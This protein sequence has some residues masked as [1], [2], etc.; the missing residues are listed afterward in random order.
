MAE[1]GDQRLEVSFGYRTLWAQLLPAKVRRR[2]AQA[3][4]EWSHQ[5]VSAWLAG[6]ETKHAELVA[7]VE[8]ARSQAAQSRA[9]A[10]GTD[11]SAPADL[12]AA[13]AELAEVS[14]TIQ[15]EILDAD[16][17]EEAA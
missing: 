13:E 12:I 3:V 16:P 2:G 11:L 7:S 9:A 17:G 15:A 8:A 1:R 10:D 14:A 5:L 6:A 4:A